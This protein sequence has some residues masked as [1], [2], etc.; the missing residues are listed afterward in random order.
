MNFQHFEYILILAEEKSF[1]KAA[2]RLFM[3]QSALSQY[4]RKLEKQLNITLFDRKNGPVTPTPEG[5]LYLEALKKTKQNMLD[6]TKQLSDLTELRLGHLS[7]G[8]SSFR[9]ANLF[10]TVIKEFQTRF[11]GIQLDIVTGNI[12]W[13]K[14]KLFSG[15]ID[16]VI[17][18]NHFEKE[19]FHYENLYTETHYL[20]LSKKHPLS[21]TIKDFALDYNEIRDEQERLFLTPA[22]PLS[23]CPD[24]P[25]IGV[26]P[27]NSFYQCHKYI[28]T[29]SGIQPNIV[30]TVDQIET[31]FR[32][33]EAGIAAALIPDSLIL[34]GNFTNHPS[35][36]KLNLLAASQE[37][38]FAVRKGCHI[39]AATKKFL[40]ILRTLIGF[41]TWDQPM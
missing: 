22:L 38:V 36:Y 33:C 30:T 14:E 24:L 34:H 40:E 10:P 19:F 20:A 27:E 1:S 31:A 23:T 11:P 4:V 29:E 8:T 28:Y 12:K 3:T 17:E 16:F 7:I 37:I 26:K 2:D 13:I 6:F 41:G 25:L 35:Y 15:E 32:W 9:A 18:N 39:S 21:E 5:E